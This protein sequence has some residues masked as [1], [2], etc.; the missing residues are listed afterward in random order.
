MIFQNQCL[1]NFQRS[2]GLA[3]VQ[4]FADFGNGSNVVYRWFDHCKNIESVQARISTFLYSDTF[5]NLRCCRLTP[6]PD[7]IRGHFVSLLEDRSEV[8]NNKKER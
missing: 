4:I 1:I 2:V 3:F 8:V 7:G 6:A 5:T